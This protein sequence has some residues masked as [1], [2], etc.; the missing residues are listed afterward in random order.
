MSHEFGLIYGVFEPGRSE[1]GKLYMAAGDT[2]FDF[3]ALDLAKSIAALPL[4]FDPGTAWSYSRST[5]VLGAVLELGFRQDA[6]CPAERE[7]LHAARHE[8]HPLLSRTR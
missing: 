3:T 2:R 7:D 4:A 8:R 1:L 6:R 5:D